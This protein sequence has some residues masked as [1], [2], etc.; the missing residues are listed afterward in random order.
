MQGYRQGQS[1]FDKYTL[2]GYLGKGAFGRV[3]LVE[4]QM[5]LPFA[6]KVIHDEVE[7]EQRGVEAVMGI[8]TNRLVRILD[9]GQTVAGEDCILMEYVK[10]SLGKVLK[11]R[12]Q[13]T[14][15]QAC[16]YFEE[17]LKGLTVLYEQAIVH[18][19]IKP[20]NLF[21]LEDI[22]KIGDFGF[23][24]FTS[25]ESSK[26]SDG[27]GTMEYMAPE[28]F[29][30]KYGYSVDM[31]AA[32]VVFV[33][34]LTG[35]CVFEAQSKVAIMNKIL[36]GVPDVSGVP[37]KYHAFM[38]K[39]FQK[40]PDDRYEDI[41]QMLGAFS[42][43]KETKRT[44]ASSKK[45]SPEPA[46]QATAKPRYKLRSEPLTVSDDE[47]K[48][49]FKLNDN[50][51][52]KAYVQNDYQDNGD[53]TIT[54]RATGLMWQQSGSDDYLAYADAEKYVA[55]LN[56]EHFAGYKD[57]RLPT[58][59]ELASLLEPDEQSN[60]QYINPVFSDEQWW[61]WSA[62]KRSSGSAWVVDF[63]YGN[64]FWYYNGSNY[65]VRAVRS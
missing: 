10:D 64:V 4:N 52:P 55:S 21:I 49:V 28:M 31:W 35:H 29:D 27:I 45:V 36:N 43:I 9:C 30:D 1:I 13:L 22:V 38:E 34:M 46:Q 19:D 54:D 53:G 33:Q 59:D 48:Q 42:G 15:D 32:A 37:E 18:R 11:E 47:Y 58:V 44:A 16:R 51:K 60:D 39:C 65:Y 24:R 3:F 63:S 17:L 41:E 40:N 50:G 2:K 5:G 23:A 57:W 12:P 25:G 26:M 8:Q 14:E 61:C 56:R 20:A 6:L 62:D 7:L